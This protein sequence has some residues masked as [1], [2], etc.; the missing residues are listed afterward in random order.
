MS[1]TPSPAA[2]PDSGVLDFLRAQFARVMSDCIDR[3]ERR[4]ERVG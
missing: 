4:L 2:S 3:V 1:E